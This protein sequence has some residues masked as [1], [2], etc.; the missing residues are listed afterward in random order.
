MSKRDYYEVLGIDRGADEDAVKKAY[1][2]MAVRYHPDRNPDDPEAEENFK[3]A[4]EAYSVLSDP[5][6]RARY[7]R[8]GH[9]GLGGGGGGFSGFDAST[10]GDFADILGDLFGMGFGGRRRRGGFGGVPGADLRYDLDISFEDA[11]FG[12]EK[13]LEYPRLEGCDAC[14]ATGSRDGKLQ[15]CSACGGQG[16]VR[17]SQGFFT[18]ARP[19]P[20][21]RGQGQTVKDPCKTCHGEGRK[22]RMR[23]MKVTIPAGVDTGMQLRLRGEGEHGMRGGPPGD[24]GVALTVLPHE[25]FERADADV[26]ERVEVSYPQLV[27]G[28]TLDIKT[29]HDEE[30]VKVPAGTQPG[31][32]IRLRGQGIPRLD[33]GGRSAHRGDHILHVHLRVP[34]PKELGEKQVELLRQMAELEGAEIHEGFME[35]MKQLFG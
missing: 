29:L 34:Q 28:T 19:C 23:K 9:E 6:K 1:R 20:Q 15:T 8:F 10:F 2:K 26:H 14:G 18:V 21:C 33:R 16:Q 13:E 11:A 35:K 30:T 27:L 7:D 4:A 5:E 22:S 3:E 32:E 31:H 25:R 24:L 12:C 17:Y